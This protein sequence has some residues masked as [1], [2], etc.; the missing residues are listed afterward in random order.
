MTPEKRRAN[1]RENQNYFSGKISELSRYMGFGLAA[2]AFSLLS[3]STEFSKGLVATVDNLLLLSAI[4]G[5]VVVLLDYFQ[6]LCGYL[7]ASQAAENEADEFQPTATGKIFSQFQGF[8]FYA[9]Q[10]IAVLGSL[11]FLAAISSALFD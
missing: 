10:V 3:R 11:L 8:S 4:A 5:C 7:A 6:M 2:A 9:K 1:Q